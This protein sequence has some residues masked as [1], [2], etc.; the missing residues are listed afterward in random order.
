MSTNLEDQS[1][2]S[3]KDCLRYRNNHVPRF[4][5][6][7]WTLFFIFL[8]YYLGVNALPDLAVWIKKIKS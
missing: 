3:E 2:G 7:A 8:I 6:F 5:R 4:L 1:S